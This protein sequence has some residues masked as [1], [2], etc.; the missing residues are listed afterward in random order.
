[1]SRMGQC[2]LDLCDGRRR[3][4]NQRTAVPSA[5][6]DE[7]RRGVLTKQ[8]DIG[9]VNAVTDSEHATGVAAVGCVTKSRSG[10]K[11]DVWQVEEVA[12]REARHGAGKFRGGI[13]CEGAASF[14]GHVGG[15]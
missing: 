4:G 3:I 8:C 7:A 11:A 6:R 9:G 13:K 2:H 5:G 14:Q 15:R 10:T 1:M 12:R